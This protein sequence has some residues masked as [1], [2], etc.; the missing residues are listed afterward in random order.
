MNDELSLLANGGG[1]E[2]DLRIS[3]ERTRYEEVDD[4]RIGRLCKGSEFM[5]DENG[6]MNEVIQMWT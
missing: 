3:M 6:S 2:Y 1:L 4:T 5:H